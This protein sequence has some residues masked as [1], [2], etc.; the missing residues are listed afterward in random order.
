MGIFP[1]LYVHLSVG[2]YVYVYWVVSIFICGCACIYVYVCVGIYVYV[3]VHLDWVCMYICVHLDYYFNINIHMVMVWMSRCLEYSGCL[4]VCN[5][6]HQ[7]SGYWFLFAPKW[8]YSRDYMCM[9]ICVCILGCIY[10]CSGCGSIFVLVVHVYMCMYIGLYLYLYLDPIL[11][12]KS[13]FVLVACMCILDCMG[14]CTCVYTYTY[15]NI[16]SW[17]ILDI[18]I[19]TTTFYKC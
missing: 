8:V 14:H 5:N 13:C 15:H 10:I 19:Q 3:C 6:M 12:K 2:I 17:I 7:Y 11:C 9:Y 18:H 16:D 1:G 4:Y